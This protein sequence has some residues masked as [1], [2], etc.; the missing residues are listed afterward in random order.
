[1]TE[2]EWELE[3]EQER[4]RKGEGRDRR[5]RRQGR[6]EENDKK[7]Q[8]TCLGYW[9]HKMY[10]CILCWLQA[11]KALFE[12]IFPGQCI[13]TNADWKKQKNQGIEY[14]FSWLILTLLIFRFL[15]K[16]SKR[17]AFGPSACSGL[18]NQ[19]VQGKGIMVWS[20][21]SCVYFCV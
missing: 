11:A 4:E 16:F 12:F 19:Y 9:W 1:M 18:M 15:V 2:Q 8:K 10:W 14:C 5:G 3:Q 6:R 7:R 20:I 13:E 21:W 17:P